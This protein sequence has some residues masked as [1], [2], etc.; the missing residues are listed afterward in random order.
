MNADRSG[1]PTNL[2]NNPAEDSFPTWSPDGKQI[3]FVSNRA[4]SRDIWVMN[5]DGNGDPTQ[6][7]SRDR[8][9]SIQEIEYPD[10]SPDGAYIIFG[11]KEDGKDYEIYIIDV[12]TAGSQP[13][14]LTDDPAVDTAPDWSPDSKQ[15]AFMSN[16][17]GND[18]IWVMNADRS[19][20]PTQLTSTPARDYAPIWSPDSNNAQIIFTRDCSTDSCPTPPYGRALY[21]MNA[22]GG[23]QRILTDHTATKDQGMPDLAWSR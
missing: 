4:G 13:K 16:R 14:P 10:W 2:T 21:I 23:E 18:H 15:I 19:G 11:G 22:N 1:K 7:T 12:T 17:S 9:G 3:A 20:E 6:L 8:T 5:A